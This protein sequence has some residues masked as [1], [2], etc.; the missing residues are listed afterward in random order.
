[1]ETGVQVVFKLFKDIF[2]FSLTV[3]AGMF[4]SEIFWAFVIAK[5]STC[6]GK[7]PK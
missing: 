3:A 6:V 5:C 1:M 4:S 2:F 7:R